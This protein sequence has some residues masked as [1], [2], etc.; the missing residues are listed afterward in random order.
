MSSYLYT[1]T[2]RQG[3][4]GVVAMKISKNG[5]LQ[6]IQGSPFQTGGKGSRSAESQNAV[7]I[8]RDLL[9]AVDVGSNSFAIF[10]RNPDGTLARLN[11]KPVSSQGIGPC[12]VCINDGI[13]YV[14]NKGNRT[15]GG[16]TQPNIAV[17]AVEGDSVKHLPQSSIKLS[18]TATATQVIVNRQGTLLAVSS[19][20]A[21]G[22]L[23]H[24]Y[25]IKRGATS[26]SGLLTKL[27]DSPFAITDGDFGFGSAWK[28]DGKTLFMTNAVGKASVLRLTIDA[29]SGKIAEKARTTAAGT[30]CWAALGRGEKK[31]YVT[32]ADSVLV[33]DV[34]GNQVTQIQSEDVSDIPNSIL[35]DVILGPDGKFLYAI[36][37][38]K[39]RI[40]VY[41]I[42]K[43]GRVARKGE[44]VI[45]GP[46]FPLGL[47][48]A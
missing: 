27:K 30:A 32:N 31:L 20:S 16:K 18:G 4:N 3:A 40:L 23:L 37:Q 47:A 17:F 39:R 29:A 34:S 28:S 36:E 26:G 5:S 10:R 11:N 42:D 7:W 13:V 44:L 6:F 19:R 15:S 46:A 9:C 1:M 24:C 43:N 48:V 12:S 8:D 41:S 21:Q 33:F 2:N 25:R 22:S 38:R 45:P 35:H 14:L